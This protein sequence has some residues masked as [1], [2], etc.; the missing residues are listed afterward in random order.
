ETAALSVFPL[1]EDES[2]AV[3]AHELRRVACVRCVRVSWKK[4]RRCE[5]K[6]ERERSHRRGNLPPSAARTNRKRAGGSRFPSAM[7]SQSA[8]RLFPSW[9]KRVDSICAFGDWFGIA[10]GK[11]DPPISGRSL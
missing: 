2:I 6:S 8:Q 11:R 9:G 10:L 7:T 3:I 4:K 5:K 1:D